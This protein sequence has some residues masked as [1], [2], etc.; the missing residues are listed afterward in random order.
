MK[1][2]LKGM[3]EINIYNGKYAKKN[4]ISRLALQISLMM[5]F[6]SLAWWL[7]NGFA[8]YSESEMSFDP[9]RFE[10]YAREGLPPAL[11]DSPGTA[12][13]V[14]FLQMLYRVSP[15]YV[16]FVAFIGMLCLLLRLVDKQRVITLAIFSPISFFYLPQTGKDGIA[17]LALIAVALAV[18]KPREYS[19]LLVAVVIVLLAF[20]VRPAIVILMSITAV[21]FRFGTKYAIVFTPLLLAVFFGGSTDLDMIIGILEDAVSDEGS[22][23]FVK[24]LRE[25]SFGYSFTPIAFRIVLLLFSV[26]IQPF[27]AIMKILNGAN[28]FVVLEG[29]C[30]L[31]FL[32]SLLQKRILMKFI[33]ASI[34]SVLAIGFVSPFYHFRYIAIAYPLIYI[35]AAYGKPSRLCIKLNR[36]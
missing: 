5:I 28:L 6:A 24:V 20:F 3:A 2:K 21:Q 31:M 8:V 18:T 14:F 23:E 15:P 29:T 7:V 33:Q 19:A 1:A 4:G 10:Y 34:P 26:V 13:I 17:I 27:V 36:T 22:G 30:L 16:G 25:Y 35:Y 11:V 9:L 32:H 12:S